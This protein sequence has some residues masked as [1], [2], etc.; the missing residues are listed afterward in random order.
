MHLLDLEWQDYDHALLAELQ[1]PEFLL[2]SAISEFPVQCLSW[3]VHGPLPPPESSSCEERVVV[4]KFDREDV[5]M[6]NYQLHMK[7]LEKFL[8]V[9]DDEDISFE[10]LQELPLVKENRKVRGGPAHACRRA[11]SPHPALSSDGQPVCS[12]HITVH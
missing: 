7:F 3:L 1:L 8:E 10:E 6:E 12:C 5:M 9:I 2:H 4:E 11:C